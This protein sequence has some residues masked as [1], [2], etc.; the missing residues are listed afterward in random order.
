MAGGT[1]ASGGVGA[2]RRGVAAQR[3][4]STG[5]S[6]S[7]PATLSGDSAILA[8]LA[9]RLP[10]RERPDTVRAYP[11]RRLA[12]GVYAVVGDTGRGSE[13]RSNAGFVVGGL[14]CC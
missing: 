3:P 8:A 6:V 11:I 1:R 4:D 5:R 12:D 2:G 14:A 7:I 9:H 13:G 10:N